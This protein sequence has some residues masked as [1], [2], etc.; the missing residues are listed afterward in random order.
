M[1]KKK[2]Y[3]GIAVVVLAAGIVNSSWVFH[4]PIFRKNISDVYAG[5][6]YQGTEGVLMQSSYNDCGPAALQMIFDRYG[7]SSTVEEIG[8]TVRLTG[9]GASMLS[10][11]QMAELKGLH[12]EGWRLT[13]ADLARASFPVM[14]FV[15]DDHFV[16]ADSIYNN[17][18]FIRDPAIGRIKMET[19]NLPKIWRG[20][21]LI[22]AQK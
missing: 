17:I 22:V 7:I 19:C 2:R 16:V 11:K 1:T 13:L 5:G 3:A 12:A 20:E 15:H 14:L 21:T 18:V 6:E 9:S 10:L 4:A 8:R